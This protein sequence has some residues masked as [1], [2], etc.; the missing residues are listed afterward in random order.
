VDVQERRVGAGI[1]SFVA[2]VQDKP[3]GELRLSHG[4]NGDAY[5]EDVVVAQDFRRQGVATALV[6]HAPAWA[7]SG[8]LPGV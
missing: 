3:A 2:Y 7:E 4:W 6:R 5:V 1:D 8:H